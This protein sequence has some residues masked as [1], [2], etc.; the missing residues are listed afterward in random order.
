MIC[1]LKKYIYPAYV[2]KHNSNCEKQAILL[3]IPNGEWRHYIAVKQ[4]SASLRGITSKY[5]G[6]SHC[7]HCLHFFRTES[8]F[9]SHKKVWENKDFYNI[10][11]PSKDTKILQLNQYQKS[12]KA[13]FIVYVDLECLTEKI[14]GCK[15]N[16]EN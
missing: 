10:V 3:M 16:P 5:H 7:L 2:S 15:T 4:L 12:C 8:K 11:M 6:D 9:K 14:N 13:P 1:I